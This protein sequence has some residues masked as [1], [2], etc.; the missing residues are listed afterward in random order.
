MSMSIA[1]IDVTR[2]KNGRVQLTSDLKIQYCT[3]VLCNNLLEEENGKFGGDVTAELPALANPEFLLVFFAYG[4]E[5]LSHPAPMVGCLQQMSHP[6]CIIS[7]RLLKKSK[8]STERPR[9]CKKLVHTPE[10]LQLARSTIS[11]LMHDVRANT[12]RKSRALSTRK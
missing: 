9:N 8:V 6:I 11:T 3:E 5:T 7:A 10:Q 12:Q 4:K 1:G 2:T